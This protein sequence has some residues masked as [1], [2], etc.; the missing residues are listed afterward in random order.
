MKKII[1]F[2]SIG[3][4]LIFTLILFLW[5]DVYITLNGEKSTTINVYNTYEEKG[6][7]ALFIVQSY[8]N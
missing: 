4:V 5:K 6:F 7:K 2:S 1:L 3:L 8:L